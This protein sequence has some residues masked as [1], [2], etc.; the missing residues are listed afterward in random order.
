MGT[1]ELE[2]R[3]CRE[4]VADKEK[5]ALE[6]RVN[7]VRAIRGSKRKLVGM[8]NIPQAELGVYQLTA[9]TESILSMRAPKQIIGTEVS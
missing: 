9:T 3:T 1:R 6:R 7:I 5:E 2:N 4:A 8:T